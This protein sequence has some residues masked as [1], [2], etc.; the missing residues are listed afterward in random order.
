MGQVNN[1]SVRV[2][3]EAIVPKVPSLHA[4]VGNEENRTTNQNSRNRVKINNRCFQNISICAKHSISFGV[5]H[6]LKQRRRWEGDIKMNVTN[7]GRG[8]DNWI[9][10]LQDRDNWQTLLN[11][12]EPLGCIKGE[13]FLETSG[14]TGIHE[15]RSGGKGMNAWGS[16]NSGF[17]ACTHAD[18]ARLFAA[19]ARYCSRKYTLYRPL[20][21]QE[22]ETHRFLN[23]RHTNVARLSALCTGRLYSP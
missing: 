18:R 23:N 10:V 6:H 4:P 1:K 11:S 22:V 19:A 9:V 20:G 3:D 5:T 17:L 2:C 7:T 21:L 16:K 8:G 13:V 15:F 14:R 12:N